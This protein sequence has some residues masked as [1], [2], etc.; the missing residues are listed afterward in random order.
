MTDKN[1]PLRRQVDR[2]GYAFNMAVAAA[3]RRSSAHQKWEC[4]GTEVPWSTKLS[5]SSG[6]IDVLIARDRAVGVIECKK[7]NVSDRLVFLTEQGQPATEPRCRLQVYLQEPPEEPK[8]SFAVSAAFSQ[9]W[10]PRFAV[11]DCT[12]PTGSPESGYCVAPKDKQNLNLDAMASELLASCDGLLGNWDVNLPAD[13]VAAVPIIVTNAQL[14]TCSFDPERADLGSGDIPDDAVFERRPFVR[15]RKA[16]GGSGGMTSPSKVELGDVAAE[17]ERTV[18]VVD[19][20]ELISFLASFR[21][22]LMPLEDGA[23]QLVSDS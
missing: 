19:S 23:C 15:F 9:R 2:S 13:Y 6:F 16:L 11:A 4:L 12:M 1:T 10:K 3:I 22:L 14:F 21:R 18:F 17:E 7:T 20:R 8:R 5:R